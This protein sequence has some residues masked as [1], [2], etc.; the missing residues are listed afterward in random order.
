[1]RH[2]LHHTGG[3]D[4]DRSPDPSGTP[5]PIAEALG[6]SPPLGVDHVVRYG[7]GRRLDFEPGARH[8]YSNF[9]YLLL[10][11]VIETVT[12]RGYEDYV[13]TEVL[14]PLG[15]AGMRLGRAMPED[16][17]AREVRYY[18]ALKRF[19]RCLHPPR[20]GQAVPLPDGADNFEV[21][22]A[23]GGWV[24]SAADLVRFAR[25]FDPERDPAVFARP[26]GPA[27]F[28]RD[29]KP[30]DRY[31]AAGWHVRPNGAG[32]RPNVWHDGTVWGCSALLVKRGDGLSWAVLLNTDSHPDGTKLPEVIDAHLHAAA[33]RVTEWPEPAAH[34]RE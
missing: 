30:L 18:D 34:F 3:W 12:G 1:V 17:F 27:G 29:G 26:A 20:L 33:D 2:C 6:V 9:G 14:A 13:R 15:C 22:E 8:V 21:Y 19:G 32:G 23:H 5:G 11:R 16:R 31:Y 24:A 10:G 4:R 28:D 7:L 25:G